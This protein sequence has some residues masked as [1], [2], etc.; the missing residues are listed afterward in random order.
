MRPMFHDLTMNDYQASGYTREEFENIMECY[1]EREPTSDNPDQ[2][3]SDLES[4]DLRA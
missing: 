3:H 2:Y 4:W 1:E